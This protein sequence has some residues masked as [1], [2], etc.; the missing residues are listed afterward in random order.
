MFID[1]KLCMASR[2][3]KHLYT[4]VAQLFYSKKS[5]QHDTTKILQQAH[6]HVDG[7]ETQE[8]VILRPVWFGGVK[9]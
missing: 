3:E 7:R 1:R 2:K 5:T 9:I 6:G 4:R 8:A